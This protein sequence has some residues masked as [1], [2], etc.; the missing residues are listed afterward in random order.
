MGQ[1]TRKG[2]LFCEALH[3]NT[4]YLTAVANDF[5]F[6]EVYSKILSFKE[7]IVIDNNKI[8]EKIE[9]LIEKQTDMH[10]SFVRDHH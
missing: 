6:S 5:S 9:I 4:S 1:L 2:S 3:V 7:H 10:A 8:N